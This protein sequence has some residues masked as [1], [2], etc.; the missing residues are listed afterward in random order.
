[1]EKVA[2]HIPGHASPTFEMDSPRI[3][4]QERSQRRSSQDQS[5]APSKNQR[6][7]PWLG[8]TSQSCQTEMQKQDIYSCIYTTDT[9]LAGRD[10]FPSPPRESVWD[11]PD[12]EDITF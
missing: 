9:F 10:V 7:L 8:W 3:T 4:T 11:H 12:I 1:M 2:H 5:M 6:N